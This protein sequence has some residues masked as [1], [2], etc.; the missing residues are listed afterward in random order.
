MRNYSRAF[1]TYDE[2]VEDL[3]NARQ[4]YAETLMHHGDFVAKL[5][6]AAFGIHDALTEE[7]IIESLRQMR[8]QAIRRKAGEE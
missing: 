3:C 2:L 5:I 1:G 8:K 4:L 7:Q 6:F